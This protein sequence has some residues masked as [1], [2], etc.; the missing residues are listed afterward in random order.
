[1]D[2][3]R[4]RARNGLRQRMLAGIGS[5]VRRDVPNILLSHNPNAF[6]RAAELGIEFTIAGHTHGGQIQVEILDRRFSPARFFTPFIAGLYRLP[7]RIGAQ[8]LVSAPADRPLDSS[9]ATS[10]QPLATLYVNRGLGTVGAPIRLGVPPEITLLI[11][12]RS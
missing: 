2:Y 1:V 7:G 6:P 5:L 12:R 4:E 10:H 3:Q 11:L 8:P 9:R